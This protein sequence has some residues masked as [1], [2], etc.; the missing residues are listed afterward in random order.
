M[1]RIWITFATVACAATIACLVGA[2]AEEKASAPSLFEKSIDGLTSQ[3]S[4]R[5]KLDSVME[6]KG[7]A[8]V[9]GGWEGWVQNPD[10]SYFRT[11]GGQPLDVFNKGEKSAY[12]EG[13]RQGKWRAGKWTADPRRADPMEYLRSLKQ[14]SAGAKFLEDETVDKLKCRVVET[15]A[16]AETVRGLLEGVGIEEGDIDW[17]KSRLELRLTVSDD[18]DCVLL[19][20]A[21]ARLDALVVDPAGGK[22]HLLAHATFDI[23]EYNKPIPMEEVP[24]QV[25]EILKLTDATTPGEEMR[26]K[27]K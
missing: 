17:E 19:R 11:T 6:A 26:G 12:R 1:K 14:Y 9:T 3:K 21:V 20:R 8:P 27:A 16:P 7:S 22:E 2:R 13:G 10:F 24:P 5:M 18:E 15:T 4:F 23:T 25:R